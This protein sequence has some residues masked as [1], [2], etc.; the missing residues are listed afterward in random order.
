MKESTHT[1]KNTYVYV[2]VGGY[3]HVRSVPV[4]QKRALDPLELGN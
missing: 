4:D 3:A 1:N 2:W